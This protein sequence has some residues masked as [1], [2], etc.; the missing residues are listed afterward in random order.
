MQ[1]P[2]AVAPPIAAALAA[3][4]PVVALETAVLTHGLPK[5]VAWATYR[6]MMDAVRAAGAVAAPV[7]MVGGLLRLGLHDS[8]H[9]LVALALDQLREL[10]RDHQESREHG[11]GGAIR[12][13][14]GPS[15]DLAGKQATT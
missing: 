2:L 13:H 3:G 6:D 1:A 9:V 8:R 15:E 11:A 7:A 5:E 10:G 4:K 12:V 14:R